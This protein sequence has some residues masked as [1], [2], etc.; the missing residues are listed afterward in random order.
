MICG[1]AALA[2]GGQAMAQ[3]EST[4]VQELVVT[5]SRIPQPNL[6]SVSPVTAISNQEIKMEGTTR[7]EDLLNNLPQAFGNMGSEV[8]NGSTGTATVDL[9]GLG[10]VRTLVLIDGRR[11]VPG[12]PTFPVTDLNFIPATLI[13]RVDVVTG[14][15][16]AVYGADAVAGVVNF[17]MMK[18]FEGVRLDAQVSGYQHSN[19]SF[20]GDI[21]RNRGFA[22]PTDN[23]W[24]GTGI[25]LTG[26]IGINSPDG[27]GNATVY[28]TYRHTDP[29]TQD[30]RDYSA[31][32]L[33][34]VDA[35]PGRFT[36]S[37]SGTGAPSRFVSFD[38][39]NANLPYDLITTGTG[40]RPRNPVSDVFNF[41]P[42]N[43]Y[44]RSDE[45]YTFGAFA[46][47]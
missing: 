25:D 39:F 46:H 40:F 33:N 17:I 27:R 43:F 22:T 34:E 31:C 35:A 23:V 47:Y 9:R 21:V 3:D 37:G 18:N 45:R 44:Q 29:I 2:L 6:T 5:G 32:S 26:I 8:S 30:K 36:C 11:V 15:A 41:A 14:G 1:A 24:D 7:V 10:P 19:D 16:S 13:D 4:E 12:D 20:V 42:Y 28:G 38:L